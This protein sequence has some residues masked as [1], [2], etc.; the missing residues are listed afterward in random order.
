[1][2]T[3]LTIHPVPVRAMNLPKL[4]YQNNPVKTHFF[5]AL[6]T[7]FPQGENFFISSIRN[8]EHCARSPALKQQILDFVTQEKNHA[9]IHKAYNRCLARAGYDV[10]WMETLLHDKISFGQ[11]HVPPLVLLAVTVATEHITAVL[12]EKVLQGDLVPEGIDPELRKIWIW[13]ALEE[14]DHKAVAMDLF[15]E[16]GG[17]YWQRVRAMLYSATGIC[18]DT[19]I[20]MFHMLK[21]DG[22]LF[23]W[24][25]WWQLAELMFGKKGL[26]PLVTWDILRFFAPGFHPARHNNYGLVDHG[27]RLLGLEAAAGH[28]P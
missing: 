6:S 19:S 25:T 22:L 27:R 3:E 21:R 24:K 8:F 12:G 4:W 26:V 2:H 28:F 17:T 13:H 7:L 5:N 18:W 11:K 16:A 10:A 14:V 15:V 9:A 20:R 1:M 23:K